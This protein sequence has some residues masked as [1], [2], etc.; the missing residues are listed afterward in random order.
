MSE[1]VHPD[2]LRLASEGDTEAAALTADAA[3][4]RAGV[5][6]GR[7]L[8]P[9]EV[10]GLVIDAGWRDLERIHVMCAIVYAESAGFA[11]AEG[12]PNSDG[13]LDLGAF[14]LNSRHADAL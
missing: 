6:A 10:A 3:E 14:Q 1:L 11:E 8:L 12:G 7:Q 9:R 2:T 5:L 13:P 4:P